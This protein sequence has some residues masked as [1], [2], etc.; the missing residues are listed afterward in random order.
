MEFDNKIVLATAFATHRV[1]GGHFSDTRRFSE[2]TAT[3][4]SNKE[5]MIYNLSPEDDKLIPADFQKFKVL[6]EDYKNAEAG[7]AFL[8]K[9]NALQIIA[10]TL[11]DFMKNL[12][13]LIKA[14]KIQRDHFGIVCLLPKIYF[15]KNKTKSLKKDMKETY[16]ASTHIGSVGDK[17]FDQEVFVTDIKFVEKFGCHA[18]NGVIGNNLISFFKEFEQGKPLPKVDATLKI[19]AKVKRHGENWITKM[20]ETQL[21]YVKILNKL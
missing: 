19:N 20:P 12:L 14:E 13:A 3:L 1:N 4:F 16:G 18:I 9:E 8:M 21:N 7:V 6:E 15:E 11:T 10:G 2:G 5:M 17:L